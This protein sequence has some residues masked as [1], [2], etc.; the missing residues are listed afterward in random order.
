MFPPAARRHEFGQTPGANPRS[1][2]AARIVWFSRREPIRRL[3][4]RDDSR[5]SCDQMVRHIET[6]A[7]RFGGVINVAKI[8]PH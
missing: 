3:T 7:R 8:Q 1:D 2:A 4:W 5:V 6:L